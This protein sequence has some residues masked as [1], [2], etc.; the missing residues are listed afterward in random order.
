M[1]EGEYHERAS[2]RSIAQRAT[3][4]VCALKATLALKFEGDSEIFFRQMSVL[5]PRSVHSSRGWIQV[6][7]K[8]DIYIYISI[9][10]CVCI[11]A[12][13]MYAFCYLFLSPPSLLRSV[14]PFLFVYF[15]LLS[16]SLS[17]YESLALC[18]G[19]CIP[20]PQQL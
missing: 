11:Y 20:R 5:L 13:Y 4:D 9:Y 6:N 3:Y 7:K 16:L 10:M 1:S 8:I 18:T 17:L 14:S 2:V 12:S 15:F 19:P